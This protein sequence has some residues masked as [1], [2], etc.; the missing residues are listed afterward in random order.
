MPNPILFFVVR[1]FHCLIR[2]KQ[3]CELCNYPRAA[4]RYHIAAGHVCE[5]HFAECQEVLD[6]RRKQLRSMN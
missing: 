1:C 6:E 2:T 5:R 3:F 4:R